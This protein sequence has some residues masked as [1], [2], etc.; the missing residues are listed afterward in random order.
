MRDVDGP[1]PL[2]PDW[3]A[4]WES[5]GEAV[6]RSAKSRKERHTPAALPMSAGTHSLRSG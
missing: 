3:I 4:C 5:P 1:R 6:A 2:D